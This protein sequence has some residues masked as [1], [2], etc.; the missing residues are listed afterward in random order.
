MPKKMHIKIYLKEY[1]EDDFY[2][3]LCGKTP[4]YLV[5][6]KGYPKNTEMP[7]SLICCKECVSRGLEIFENLLST[8]LSYKKEYEKALNELFRLRKEEL[9]RVRNN[10]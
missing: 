5:K 10:A 7:F 4:T 1:P 3:C 2:T 8:H 6:V 9:E